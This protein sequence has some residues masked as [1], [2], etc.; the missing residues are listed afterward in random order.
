MSR[1]I[2]SRDRQNV[3]VDKWNA[4][5]KLNTG[6]GEVWFPRGTRTYRARHQDRF[7]GEVE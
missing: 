7:R 3:D 2:V 5:A 1:W 4:F 6:D